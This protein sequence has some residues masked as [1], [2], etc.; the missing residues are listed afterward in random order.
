MKINIHYPDIDLILS[1]KK[2]KQ[3]T[4][5]SGYTVRQ[6]QEYLQLSCPQ[7]VYRWFKGQIMPSLQH[8]Y[9]L[10]RLFHVHME[11]LFVSKDP[12]FR[13]DIERFC[14]KL[15]SRRLCTYYRL[16]LGIIQIR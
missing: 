14:S 16:L 4:E 6:I 2:L 15:C 11:E 13:V 7:P 5:K 9:A 10:S 8:A 12:V 1:G 3:L